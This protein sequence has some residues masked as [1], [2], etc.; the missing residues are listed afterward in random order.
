M[1]RLAPQYQH[2]AVSK[3]ALHRDGATGQQ[4]KY[5]HGTMCLIH[6][7]LL[8]HLEAVPLSA[9]GLNEEQIKACEGRLLVTC[10]QKSYTK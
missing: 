2:Y 7:E 9:C 4:R 10:G 6:K 3:Q 1:A 8:P 5:W